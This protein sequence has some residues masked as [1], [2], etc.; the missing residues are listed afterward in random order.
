MEERDESAD[1]FGERGTMRLDGPRGGREGSGG[2]PRTGGVRP[3]GLDEAESFGESKTLS[4]W[5][6][7][8]EWQGKRWQ[9][10][11]EILG[12]Y[13]VEG[14]LGQGGMGVVYECS[15]K[16]GGVKV[17]VKALPPELSHNS[18]EMEEVRANFQLVYGLSHPNI[19]RWSGTSGGSTSW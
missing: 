9:A 14:E 8:E 17:A 5:R 18:D 11:E 1:S 15:D 6:T 4:G 16:V 10:G 19:G 2:E 12:R 3:D 13:V 7:Q